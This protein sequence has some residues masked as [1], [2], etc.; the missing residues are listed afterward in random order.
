MRHVWICAALL[1]LLTACGGN[2]A[3]ISGNDISETADGGNTASVLENEES[4]AA[5]PEGNTASETAAV[6]EDFYLVINELSPGSTV[7]KFSV[8][9]A[10]GEDAEILLIPRLEIRGEDGEWETISLD[11]RLGFCG[12]PDPLPVGEKEWSVELDRLWNNL[13]A[14]EYRLSF[15]V[16]DAD[17]QKFTA[18]GEFS[19]TYDIVQIARN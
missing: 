10:A 8:V 18:C 11:E 13:Y 19:L 12:T 9:N 16:T 5:L 17:G 15:T 14:G 3:P 6:S 7:L 4:G 1:V 2:T